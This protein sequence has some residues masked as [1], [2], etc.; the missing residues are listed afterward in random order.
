MHSKLIYDLYILQVNLD[1]V[2]IK[3]GY[4]PTLHWIHSIGELVQLSFVLEQYIYK[5]KSP[6]KKIEHLNSTPRPRIRE[7]QSIINRA[8]DSSSASHEVLGL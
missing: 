2:Q 6:R 1:I 5:S 3:F 8:V 7:S 4:S